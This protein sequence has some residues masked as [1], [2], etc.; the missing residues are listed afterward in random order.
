LFS[1]HMRM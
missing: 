1:V